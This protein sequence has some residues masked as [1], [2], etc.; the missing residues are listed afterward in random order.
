M[1]GTLVL[2]YNELDWE[3]VRRLSSLRLLSLSLIGNSK[4]DSDPHCK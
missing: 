1:L 4:I 2:A 3:E